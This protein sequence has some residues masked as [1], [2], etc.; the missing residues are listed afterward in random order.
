MLRR[1]TAI[2]LALV[3]VGLIFYRY[4]SFDDVSWWNGSSDLKSTSR[5]VGS[6]GP[7]PLGGSSG[8]GGEDLVGATPIRMLDDDLPAAEVTRDVKTTMRRMVQMEGAAPKW[9][10]APRRIGSI[11]WLQNVCLRQDAHTTFY[12]PG[13][14][15]Q[16]RVSGGS[17]GPWPKTKAGY[18]E[19]VANLSHAF[20]AD[21]TASLEAR[22]HPEHAILPWF[23]MKYDA[24]NLYHAIED[25]WPAVQFVEMVSEYLA[26]C[27]VKTRVLLRQYYGKMPRSLEWRLFK[28]ATG[29]SE[30]FA[31]ETTKKNVVHC[32]RGAWMPAGIPSGY[33]A[34]DPN[35]IRNVDWKS[36]WR[37]NVELL[38]NLSNTT[39]LDNCAAPAAV[40]RITVIQRLRT[41]RIFNLDYIVLAMRKRGWEVRVVNL[42]DFSVTDQYLIMQNTTTLIAYHGAGLAWARVLPRHA[43]EI[44]VIGL[45]CS[46]EPRE[47]GQMWVPKHRYRLVHSSV[48]AIGTDVD[49]KAAKRYCDVLHRSN[50]LGVRN[51]NALSKEELQIL[52]TGLK[53]TAG[54]FCD[55]ISAML[56]LSLGVM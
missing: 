52:A 50:Q 3:V 53:P 51:R 14:I 48:D 19:G 27:D 45:P 9:F 46:I 54:K 37:A 22:W 7:L 29:T 40:P 6:G 44:Q 5:E 36:R 17:W 8:T 38:G 32:F 30:G 21:S 25:V 41:R 11:L 55:Q 28:S 23:G 1:T 42:E 35:P 15:R 56:L 34:E 20:T 4:V 39:M 12:A 2:C 49:E 16:E 33:T 18:I 26:K 10:N 24:N 13:V 31:V 47:S 43:A